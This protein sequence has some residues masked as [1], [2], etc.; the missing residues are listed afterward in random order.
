MGHIIFI[1]LYETNSGL[2]N[3][4]LL[5]LMQ[6]HSNASKLTR[7]QAVQ[8]VHSR[9]MLTGAGSKNKLKAKDLHTASPDEDL[10]QMLLCC[11]K[12]IGSCQYGMQIFSLTFALRIKF[13]HL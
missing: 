11:I 12:V 6:S 8:S 3:L 13:D 1:S 7:I 5:Y 2:R 9:K 4:L 10:E